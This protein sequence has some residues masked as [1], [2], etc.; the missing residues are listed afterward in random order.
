MNLRCQLPRTGS[1]YCPT[2]CQSGDSLNHV[3]LLKSIQIWVEDPG[4]LSFSVKSEKLHVIPGKVKKVKRKKFLWSRP[5]ARLE[6]LYR[7]RNG[8]VIQQVKKGNNTLWQ[9]RSAP[10]TSINCSFA[11]YLSVYHRPHDYSAGVFVLFT[12]ACSVYYDGIIPNKCDWTFLSATLCVAGAHHKRQKLIKP[13]FM[14][15]PYSLTISRPWNKN[16]GWK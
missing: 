4:I 15:N 14:K 2:D 3:L 12:V 7:Y 11:S 1:P 16:W 5:N 6:G 9:A 13:G 8:G 10:R